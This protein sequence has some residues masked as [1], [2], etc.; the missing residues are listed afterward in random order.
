MTEPEK[1]ALEALAQ[2]RLPAWEELP[3]LA[4]YMDQVLSL[5]ARYLPGGEDKALTAAMVNNYV[6]QKVL[7]PPVSK[8]YGRSHLAA[9]L[10]LCILKSVMP[11][12]DIQRLFQSAGGEEGIQDLYGEF[13][14]IYS[15]ANQLVARQ[16]TALSQEGRS[17]FLFAALGSR[18]AQ[19]LAAALLPGAA[20]ASKHN[21]G[22]EQ[23]K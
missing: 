6:K 11:I 13:C 16:L 17:R 19:E 20:E 18:A 5:T 12:A 3:D 1:S 14:G 15:Q 22:K 2:R 23:E 7:P 8:R 10:M 21:M 4:L 9:L